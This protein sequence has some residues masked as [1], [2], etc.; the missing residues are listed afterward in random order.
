MEDNDN[1]NETARV[2]MIDGG[3][4]KISG[5]FILEDF[6]RD[7]VI[8]GNQTIYLCTCGNSGRMPYCDESHLKKFIAGTENE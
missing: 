5:N 3:P 2:E 1:K 7:I 8:K 4:V 6:K